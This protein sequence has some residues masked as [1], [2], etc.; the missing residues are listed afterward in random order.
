MLPRK[1]L[2]PLKSEFQRIRQDG[3]LYDSPSFGLV[4]SYGTKDGSQ[5]AFVV[6]KKID[7]KAVVRHAVKRKLS[8]AV[9]SF[10]P[11]LPKNA[12]VLFLAKQQAIKSEIA[13]LRDE[14]EA[15]LRRA[16]LV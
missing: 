11:R 6:S 15:V 3:K 8:E 2:I 12:E 1:K 9:T 13:E 10:L 16:K 14:I 4:I 5:A 7:K